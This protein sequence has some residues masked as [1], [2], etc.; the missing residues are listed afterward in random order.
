MLKD[1]YNGNEIGSWM[2]VEDNPKPDDLQ[3]VTLVFYS[4]MVSIEILREDFKKV[5]EEIYRASK[6]LEVFD[7]RN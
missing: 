1:L 4:N 6:A 3:C 5:A 2:N 7:A